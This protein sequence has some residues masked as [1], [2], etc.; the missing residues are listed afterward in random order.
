MAKRASDLAAIYDEVPEL[1]PNIIAL[2][3]AVV[4]GIISIINNY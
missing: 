1:H 4:S 3:V 2:Y